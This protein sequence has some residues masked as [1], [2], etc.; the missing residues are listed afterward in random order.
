MITGAQNQAP[1]RRARLLTGAE[2][3]AAGAVLALVPREAT[4]TPGVWLLGALL[5]L[6]SLCLWLRGG[7]WSDVGLGG[8]AAGQR[9]EWH[10][11]LGLALGA[12]A[13]LAASFAVGPGLAAVTSRSLDAGVPAAVQDSAVALAL[14]LLVAWVH[15]LGAEMIFRGWLLDRAEAL[16]PAGAASDGGEDSDG[17]AAGEAFGPL[18]LAGLAYGWYLGDGSAGSL[19]SGALLG[20]GLCL[21]RRAGQSLTLPIAT[22]GA[23]ASTHVV[24]VY[25]GVLGGSG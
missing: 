10:V 24:L 6:G 12:L 16:W 22:H 9:A 23:Y 13:A 15:A 25:A 21:L 7:S 5:V 11:L 8:A 3:V 4:G 2:L 20:V 17:G 19:A 18:V 14:A 1:G